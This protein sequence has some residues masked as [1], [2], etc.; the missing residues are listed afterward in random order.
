M[1][2]RKT[3]YEWEWGEAFLLS[4]ALPGIQLHSYAKTTVNGFTSFAKEMQFNCAPSWQLFPHNYAFWWE[5]LTEV[6]HTF[7]VISPFVE[8]HLEYQWEYQLYQWLNNM[9]LSILCQFKNKLIFLLPMFKL[10]MVWYLNAVQE[11]EYNIIQ[12]HQWIVFEVKR[13]LKIIFLDCLWW[14]SLKNWLGW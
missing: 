13:N 2:R 10:F 3:P 4:S 14:R 8:Y 1:Q 12:N 11:G 7:V 5:P 9:R 6:W